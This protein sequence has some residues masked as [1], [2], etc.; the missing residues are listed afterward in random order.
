MKLLSESILSNDRE[1]ALAAATEMLRD[2]LREMNQVAELPEFKATNPPSFSHGYTSGLESGS[3]L[4]L[5]E[6][7]KLVI[8]GLQ[9]AEILI[10]II[11]LLEAIH[12]A[13]HVINGRKPE[14]IAVDKLIETTVIVALKDVLASAMAPAP[15]PFG[16]N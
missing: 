9:P 5:M 3:L 15:S 13:G 14:C 10:R 2:S 16:S 8:S 4:A 11:S 7:L 12:Y 1:G 6:T